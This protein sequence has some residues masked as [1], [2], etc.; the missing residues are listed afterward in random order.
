MTA[1]SADLPIRRGTYRLGVFGSMMNPPHVG[2]LAVVEAVHT[3][4]R[5]DRIVVVPSGIPPHRAEPTVSARA[6]LT[7]A[8]RAF[9]DLE[10]VVVSD[11]EV[12]RGEH[13]EPG[14]MVDTVEEMLDLPGLLGYDDLRVEASLIVGADQAGSLTAWHRWQDLLEMVQLLVVGRPDQLGDEALDA[15]LI[16]LGEPPPC[17]IHRIEMPPVAISSTL[18]RE[19]AASGNRDVV[20]PLVPGA[21]L[22]DVIQLYGP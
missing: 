12:E 20:A 9:A 3:A 4:C 7:M 21:I 18:V 2:H 17:R 8:V 14:Y 16:S 15:A 19:I 6:R 22:D 13:G 11:T 10:H 1:T 5:L